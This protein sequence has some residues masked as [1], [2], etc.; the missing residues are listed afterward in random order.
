MNKITIALV[1]SSIIAAA[2]LGGCAAKPEI[3][4]VTGEESELVAEAVE[5]VAEN[6]LSG[7][8]TND[9]D[10]FV[11]NFDETMRKAITPD[12]FSKIA[13]QIGKHGTAQSLDLL[14]IEDQGDYYGVNYG[15]NYTDAKVIL[16]IV[17][18]KATPDLVSGLWFK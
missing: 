5:P 3:T 12:A 2:L 11:T 10:L 1:L 13:K 17:V 6:I 15:V 18:A 14:N 9:Y 7:I 16:R 8:E 4:Y